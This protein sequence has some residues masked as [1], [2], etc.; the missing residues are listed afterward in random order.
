MI[1]KTKRKTH[2]SFWFKWR[3]HSYLYLR[4]NLIFIAK[5]LVLQGMLDDSQKLKSL[6]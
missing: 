1:K 3:Q 2:I 6:G 4:T 5:G